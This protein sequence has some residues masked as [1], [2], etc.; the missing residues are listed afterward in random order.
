MIP[1]EKDY[2]YERKFL[3]SNPSIK[4]LEDLFYLM[5]I[6]IYN[7]YSPRRVNSIYFDTLNYKLAKSN[8]DGDFKRFKVRIR[9]YGEISKFLKP[10]LEIKYKF[11]L[12]GKKYKVPLNLD[13]IIRNNFSL[14]FLINDYCLPFEVRK[15]L[16]DLKPVCFVSY[17]RSYYI[18]KSK[19]YRLTF[20]KDLFFQLVNSNNVIS[21][22]KTNP[23]LFN[24][25]N[26]LEIKYH[27]ENDQFINIFSR[28]M[29]FRLST[30]SKYQIGLEELKLI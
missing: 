19:K 10:T 3:F 5:P 11:G 25:I 17:I 22:I 30:C 1:K 21:S 7:L 24:Y 23:K 13:H 8:I 18:C 12:M 28:K 6:N 14:D 9:F 2:R 29:P 16:I 15:I 27:Y 20:D 26:I 4:S